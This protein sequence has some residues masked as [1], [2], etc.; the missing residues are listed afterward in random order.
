MSNEERDVIRAMFSTPD[1]L[2]LKMAESKSRLSLVP[3][4]V[5]EELARVYEYGAEK[6]HVGSWKH[7]TREQAQACLPDAAMRH[8]VAY[9]DGETLDPES[10][11]NHLAQ[12][13]WNCLT[14]MYH[15]K[16]TDNG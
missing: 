4:F 10:S 6:Y 5:I 12:C 7:F 9:C 8:L 13:A 14:L 15:E 11:L 3:R 1:A 16:E 2:P